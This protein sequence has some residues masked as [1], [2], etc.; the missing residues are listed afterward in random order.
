MYESA[1]ALPPS[2]V[3]D[4]LP[5]MWTVE[6]PPPPPVSSQEA[7]VAGASDREVAAIVELE[8]ERECQLE[9]QAEWTEWVERNPGRFRVPTQ[10]DF[11]RLRREAASPRPPAMELITPPPSGE[12]GE[13][14]YGAV[15]GV[16]GEGVICD[17]F[18]ESGQGPAAQ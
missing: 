1:E 9:E 8:G 18:G 3:L 2:A 4:E 16:T 5:L 10:A 17:Q 12:P 13:G 11:E 14:Q 6:V 15:G 7:M